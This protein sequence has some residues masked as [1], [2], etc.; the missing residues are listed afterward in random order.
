MAPPAAIA[1]GS[2]LIYPASDIITLHN[3]QTLV[4]SNPGMAH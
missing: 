1:K 2:A 3:S 4:Y